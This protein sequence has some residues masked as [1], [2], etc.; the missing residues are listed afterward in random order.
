MI[1]YIIFDL[2]GVL[3]DARELH[4]EALN[5][6]LSKFGCTIARDE[7]LSTYDGLPTRKKLELLTQRKG[8]SPDLYDQIWQEKQKATREIIDTQ[9]TY[10]ERMR[11]IL[12]KLR[13]EGY[14]LAVCSNSIRETVK[15]MLLRKGLIEFFD[16]YLSNE[17]VRLSKPHPE[18]YLRAFLQ[19]GA[20]PKECL[21]VE[22][23]HHGREAAYAAGAHICGVRDVF[24]VSYEKIRLVLDQVDQ[25]TKGH[26]FRPK[27][28]GGDL[29]IVIPMAGEGKSYQRAG[30]SFPKPLVDV[31]GKPMIQHIVENINVD[32]QFIF[33]VLKEH[34]E[35]YNL[36][37]LLNLIAPGCAIVQLDKPTQGAAFSVLAA[38]A[39]FNNEYPLVIANSDQVIE[40]NS[41]EFFYAMAADG[42][43]G[44]VVTFESTHPKWS[45]VRT[46]EN[47]LVIEAAE[48]K[49][50]S[51]QATTG[52]Y[53]FSQGRE[54]SRYIR[55]M[56][57]KGI[58]T[59]NEY[60]VCPVFNEYIEDHKKIR[61]FPIEK[62][63]SFSTPEDLEE[64][65]QN[66]TK[67]L[68][69]PIQTSTKPQSSPQFINP[70]VT[71]EV[72]INV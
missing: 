51:N 6:A 10:D 13:E 27:W 26:R 1:K 34:Y 65:L 3:V 16:F 19:F 57:Q 32:G 38:E 37:Y 63:W 39:L 41:N 5:R 20:A 46:G 44:G 28:Q 55:Q 69:P 53:Y 49:P 30:Y 47:G 14:R 60:Y 50:I 54:F 40:W 17:D 58:T 64:F 45:Y 18:M 21:V 56:I 35:R 42:C 23:S 72:R 4:Y 52:I 33:V 67:D 25:K 29:K 48:K 11:G 43:D 15:M 2:D 9:F 8:L 71:K 31:E 36:K 7:H 22:D 68:S 70:I 12:R 66:H 62:M 24:D 61:T 59:N